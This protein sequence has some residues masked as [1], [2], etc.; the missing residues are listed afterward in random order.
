MYI[1]MHLHMFIYIYKHMYMYMFIF[2]SM[3]TRYISP[4]IGLIKHHV[5]NLI[6]TYV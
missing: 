3:F 4:I 5:I 2:S 1:H 6:Y